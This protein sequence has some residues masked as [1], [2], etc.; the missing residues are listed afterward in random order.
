M[1]TEFSDPLILWN[2]TAFF[3]IST[4]KSP[5]PSQMPQFVIWRDIITKNEFKDPSNQ[6]NN[7]E[8][9]PIFWICSQNNIKIELYDFGPPLTPQYLDS[10]ISDDFCKIKSQKQ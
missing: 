8:P 10:M 9:P 6:W 2:D 1:T 3:R 5:L 4:L 7:T